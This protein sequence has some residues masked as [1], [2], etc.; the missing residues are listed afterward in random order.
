VPIKRFIDQYS[1]FSP[2]VKQ[3]SLLVACFVTI[4]VVHRLISFQLLLAENLPEYVETYN[5]YRGFNPVTGLIS[6]H[7]GALLTG[8]HSDFI[9]AIL[10]AAIL[11][12]LPKAVTILS[13]VSLSVFYAANLEH[14]RYNMANIDLSLI[15]LGVD[16]TFLAAQ[17]TPDLF[18]ALGKFLA[19]GLCMLILSRIQ[20]GRRLAAVIAV[21]AVPFAI[22]PV[23]AVDITQ[24][25]WLQ[26]HPLLP[27]GANKRL[28]SDDR[29]FTW[30]DRPPAISPA[31]DAGNQQKNLLIVYLEG[32]SEVSLRQGHMPNL[33][34]MAETQTHYARYFAHQLVTVNGLYSTLTGQLPNFTGSSS[35]VL[36]F[37]M[38]ASDDEVAGSLPHQLSA[39]GYHTAFIQSANLGFMN[40]DTMLPMLGFD[41]IK[42]D[43]D[44]EQ[45]HSKNGWGIDDLSLMENVIAEID[46]QP[47]GQPWMIATLTTGTHAPYNVPATFL[48]DEGSDRTR[49]LR[50]ADEAAAYLAQEL[51]ARNL[52]ENTVV[53]FTSDESREQTG[54][55][56]L[57]DEMAL[58]WLPL[59]IMD[60]DSPARASD[61]YIMTSDLPFLLMEMVTGTDQPRSRAVDAP[62]VFGN[63]IKRRFFWYEPTTYELWACNT[64]DFACGYYTGVT[65]LG[66]IGQISPVSKA[67]FPNLQAA[68]ERQ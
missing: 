38:N 13:F 39:Q 56:P 57:E 3:F 42:G 10:L 5:P 63:I 8:I 45:W 55:S 31:T 26:A 34:A 22:A 20:I 41:E 61:A 23:F 33:Q 58:N 4:S 66:E 24:P 62:I 67:I 44:F 49:A 65:D 19:I 36:W 51:R 21:V 7:S 32:I 40:K 14:L 25:M 54:A 6:Q 53:V 35:D 64:A 30:P 16:P 2:L 52:L 68:V 60:T 9:F 43:G 28:E 15:G 1:R 29:E 59:I 37:E 47:E 12:L 46:A 27:I 17:L 11:T 50:W 48:P 18:L